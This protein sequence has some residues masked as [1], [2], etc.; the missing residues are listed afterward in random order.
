MY[1]YAHNFEVPKS[2]HSVRPE[3]IPVLWIRDIFCS[4]PD[5]TLFVSDLQDANQKIFFRSFFAYYF[6]KVHLH[7][8]SKIKSHKEVKNKIKVFL[9]I[10]A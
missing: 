2:N 8:S 1:K 9:T 4:D 7:R 3:N 5:P 10:F 6:L